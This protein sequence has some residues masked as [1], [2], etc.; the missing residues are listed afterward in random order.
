M[1]HSAISDMV[2][3]GEYIGSILSL[4]ARQYRVYAYIDD[5]ENEFGRNINYNEL[6]KDWV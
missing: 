5:I 6:E 4:I 1:V 2:R 3:N